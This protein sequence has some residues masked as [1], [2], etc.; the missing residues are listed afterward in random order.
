VL[1][2]E[3]EEDKSVVTVVGSFAAVHPGATLCIRG[4]WCRNRKYGRQLRAHEY[5]ETAPATQ[6]GM[7][8]YL[9]SGLVKGIGPVVAKAIVSHFGADTSRVLNEE[10]LRLMEVDGI[11]KKK[12]EMIRK[13]WTDQ[14]DVTSVM[15]F[16]QVRVHVLTTTPPCACRA[17][18][19]DH[20]SSPGLWSLSSRTT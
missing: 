17:Y 19:S 12:A 7:E 18:L 11:G 15:M 20:E 3:T 8:N 6:A 13:A 16:L 14:R 1:R 10:P 4:E 5:S 9:A 2:V